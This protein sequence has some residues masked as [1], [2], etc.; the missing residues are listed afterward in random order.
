MSRTRSDRAAR[1]VN[2]ALV[3]ASGLILSACGGGFLGISDSPEPPLPGERISLREIPTE[4]DVD[5]VVASGFAQLP[6]PVTL[7]DWTHVNGVP[8]HAAGHIIGPSGLNLAWSADVGDGDDSARITSAPIVAGGSVFVIDGESVVTAT[9]TTN[10]KR[11]WEVELAPEGEDG[12]DGFGGGV[13]YANGVVF[14]STGFGEVV[15]LSAS[16]GS[17]LWRRGL[18]APMRAAPTVESGR[19]YAV[20]RDNGAFA[21]SAAD[22]SLQWR[23]Q[24]SAGTLG[25]LGGAS[26]AVIGEAVILPFASGEVMAVRASTGAR[27]W[28]EVLS[29][30]RRGAARSI[31]NDIT[32]DPVIAGQ[33]V[34]A[35]NQ[36]GVM[37]A[38]E[39][40]G[41]RRVWERRFGAVGPVWVIGDT[42]F[43]VTD[44]ARVVRLRALSGE[45]IWETPLP[46]F[47]DPDDREEVI[48]YAGPVVASGKVYVAS[49][50]EGLLR[51]DAASGARIESEDEIGDG[52]TLSPV[53]AGGTVYLLSDSGRLFAYR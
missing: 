44:D 48:A 53:I 35:A 13:A 1:P 52:S 3:L 26:P 41:G 31:I 2:V 18:G 47:A 10:G 4:S 22:G 20:T 40:R 30:G 51:L 43:A 32:S 49:S 12:E 14:A 45:T 24:G 6:P 36:S 38:V 15:A 11:R 9:S 17:E 46:A 19:V 39:G 25:L 16:D 42:L 8:T 5:P 29:S 23:I 21:L 34:F 50:E 28:S 33:G 27:V 7:N 37:V